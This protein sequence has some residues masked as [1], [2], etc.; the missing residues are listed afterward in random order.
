[1][2]VGR[3]VGVFVGRKVG[4]FVGEAV[5][6]NDNMTGVEVGGRG[7]GVDVGPSDEAGNIEK[8][9]V[10]IFCVTKLGTPGV[11]GIIALGDCT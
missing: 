8:P 5:C 3:G 6:V 4:E 2:G 11:S 7:D 9:G 10:D 1:M